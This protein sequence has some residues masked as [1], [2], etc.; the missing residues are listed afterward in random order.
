MLPGTISVQD[1]R[2]AV[3]QDSPSPNDVLSSALV[4]SQ[5]NSPSI[6]ADENHHVADLG[7]RPPSNVSSSIPSSGEKTLGL[8]KAR[9]AELYG[10]G[11]DMEPI[12]MRHRP[13]DPATNEY[14]LPTHAIRLVAAQDQGVDYPLTFHMVADERSADYAQDSQIVDAIEACVKPHG[15]KLVRLFWKMVQPTYSIVHKATFVRKY[16]ESYRHIDAPLLGAVYLITTNWWHYDPHLSHQPLIDVTVL[17]QLT[18]EAIQS[19]YHRP[20]LS[21][22]EAILLFLQCKPEDPL[23]PDHT[24]AWGLTGQA[25]SVGEAL[26]LHLDASSW[27][28]P[29]WERSLRKRLSWA[30]YMQDVWTAL[31]HGRPVHISDDDWAV[32]SLKSEDFPDQDFPDQEQSFIALVSLARILHVVV[33]QFYSLQSST[34]QDTTQLYSKA[35]PLWNSLGSWYLNLPSP[36]SMDNLPSRQLCANG[37]VHLAFYAVKISILRRLVRSTALAPLCT[38]V[39]VLNTIR[40]QAHETAQQA[41]VLVASLRLEHLD[42][43][44]YFAAPYYFSVIGSFFVLLLVTSLTPAERDH[45]R[46]SLRSFLWILRVGCKSNEPMRYAVNRLEGAILR[47]LEH[48]LAV[49]VDATSPIV[50]EATSGHFDADID[51]FGFSFPETEGLDFATMNLD[52]FDFLSN[53]ALN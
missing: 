36:L 50:P 49:A 13:Y 31:V 42:A 3:V 15:E 6:T 20:R 39:D 10:L 22:I 1:P 5:T 53:V 51:G 40:Q 2:P 46:E 32:T 25:L 45:W 21:S 16:S 14:T 4:A 35:C 30:L 27:E 9:F 34:L 8:D 52:A 26:G 7:L 43:F 28:V 24:Y 11:S 38:D 19:S 33:K 44:W 17:R 48:A 29:N 12:L 47:G 41:I 37:N 23:N 18:L